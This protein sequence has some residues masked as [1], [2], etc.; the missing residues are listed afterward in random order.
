MSAKNALPTLLFGGSCDKL[1]DLVGTSRDQLRDLVRRTHDWLTGDDV[2]IRVL[3]VM[4]Y[5]QFYSP[6]N[7]TTD[8][9]AG[10]AKQGLES[11]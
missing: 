1:R 7:S 4:L 5:R 8:N 10:S 3:S 9:K 6:Q 2:S 11:Q